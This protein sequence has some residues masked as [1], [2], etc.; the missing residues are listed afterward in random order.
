MGSILYRNDGAT[1]SVFTY[2]FSRTV[3]HLEKQNEIFRCGAAQYATNPEAPLPFIF[4]GADWL[5]LRAEMRKT[6]SLESLVVPRLFPLCV[7]MHI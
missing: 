7:L 4:L 3:V 2:F 6:V 1:C 5:P